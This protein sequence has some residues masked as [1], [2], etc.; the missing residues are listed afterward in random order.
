LDRLVPVISPAH[1]AIGLAPLT[2]GGSPST[3][4]STGHARQDFPWRGRRTAID[5]TLR[6]DRS[7]DAL[8]DDSL[9]DDDALVTT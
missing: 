3:A 8:G 5:Q 1:E 4:I 7:A 2:L 6:G 9:H